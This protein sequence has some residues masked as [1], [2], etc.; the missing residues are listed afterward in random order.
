M[1]PQSITSLEDTGRL[2]IG[3]S[4]SDP[5]NPDFRTL[6]KFLRRPA[7]AFSSPRPLPVKHRLGWVGLLLLVAV[8]CAALDRVVVHVFH[9]PVPVRGA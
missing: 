5:A 9:W 3:Q 4:A 1:H 6:L 7:F 8:L 2:A